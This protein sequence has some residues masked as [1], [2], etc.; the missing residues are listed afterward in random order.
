MVV[1]VAIIRV[2]GP[3]SDQQG[4]ELNTVMLG[5]L[6]HDKGE[7]DDDEDDDGDDDG[8]CF[9]EGQG[10]GAGAVSCHFNLLLSS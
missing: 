8:E 4:L 9:G 6:Y 10:L 1:V 7:E 2:N 5:F 3:T